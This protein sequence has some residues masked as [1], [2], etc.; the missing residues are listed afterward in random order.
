MRVWLSCDA[1]RADSSFSLCCCCY[2]A[3]GGLCVSCESK[4]SCL[5]DGTSTSA[6]GL[7]PESEECLICEGDLLISAVALLWAGN[8]G[9]TAAVDTVPVTAGC[10]CMRECVRV[11]LR[12]GKVPHKII[13][14]KA[15]DPSTLGHVEWVCT[16]DE[17]CN[18]G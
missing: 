5:S 10:A 4:W 8:Q 1:H 13:E 7:Q 17:V 11:W 14:M 2:A 12:S 9:E 16:H 3:M 15:N 6:P 18:K